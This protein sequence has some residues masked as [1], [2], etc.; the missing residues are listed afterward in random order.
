MQ[1]FNFEALDAILTVH[2]DSD[3]AGCRSSRKSTSGAVES[4]NVVVAKHWRST[5]RLVALSSRE[6]QLYALNKG[7]EEAMGFRS[8]AEDVGITF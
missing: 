5:Q 2:T 8:L 3:W 6:A 4:T 7:S 1:E